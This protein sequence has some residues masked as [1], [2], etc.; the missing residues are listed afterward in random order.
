VPRLLVA[1]DGGLAVFNSPGA[2]PTV[3][4]EG[5]SVQ[6]VTEYDGR[7]WAAV[8]REAVWRSDADGWSVLA[9]TGGASPT[10]LAWTTTLLVG[11]SGAHLLREHDGA[12]EPVASFDEAE[13]RDDWYTP[14]GGPPDTRSITEWD[15][16]VYVNV[17][18]GGILRTSDGGASWMPTIDIDAD[19]HQVTVTEGHLFAA[20]ASGL[21]QSDDRG[22]TWSMRDDGLETRYARSVAICGDAVLLTASNGP[23]G[24]NAA[25]YRAD[26]AG[27]PFARRTEPVDGNIDTHCLDALPDGSAAAYGTP[28]GRLFWSAD[29]GATWEPTGAVDGAVRYLLVLP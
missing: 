13:G 18:V 19:V 6:A 4:L 1:T 11:T 17:H 15:D 29:Q 28:D 23:R 14:W 26:L 16:D 8:D 25:V 2:T 7:V 24:G 10:C 5:H 22:G 12:L 21:A 20:C 3:D 9:N 27:G